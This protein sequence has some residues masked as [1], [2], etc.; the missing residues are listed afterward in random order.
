MRCAL[1][2]SV[3]VCVFAYHVFSFGVILIHLDPIS[4][5]WG[6]V[7]F[8]S[9]LIIP[10]AISVSCIKSKRVLLWDKEI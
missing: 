8:F 3:Y 4:K 7:A 10:L 9:V 1:C 2:A 6:N 5:D